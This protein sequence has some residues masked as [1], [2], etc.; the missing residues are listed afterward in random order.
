MQLTR[1]TKLGMWIVRFNVLAYTAIEI[2]G[3]YDHLTND[4]W[5]VHAKF[6]AVSGLLWLLTL[7]VV[8]SVLL[9]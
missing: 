1:K 5:D 9:L 7:F 4:D 8:A 2:N 3:A 6:H